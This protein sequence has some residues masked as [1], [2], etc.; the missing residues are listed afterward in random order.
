VHQVNITTEQRT[1]KRHVCYR[2]RKKEKETRS[3]YNELTTTKIAYKQKS[4]SL[5]KMEQ[6]HKQP[7][8][9]NRIQNIASHKRSESQKIIPL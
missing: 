1:N 2:Q 6:Q 9:G 3:D 4:L 7:T 5:H 8:R